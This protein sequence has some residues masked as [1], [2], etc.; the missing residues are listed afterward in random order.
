MRC[1]LDLVGTLV[2]VLACASTVA[3]DVCVP[4]S[5]SVHGL[6]GRV[7]FELNGKREPLPDVQV[8]VTPYGYKKPPVATSVTNEVG[9]F[10]LRQVRPGRYYLTVRHAVVIGLSVEV[11]V[12]KAKR[13]EEDSTLIE[14]VLRNDPTKYC[15]GATV[16]ARKEISRPSTARSKIME[17][18]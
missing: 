9:E 1:L 10:L 6:R 7:Y 13:A 17:D 18:R 16:I 14:I 11:R 15:A 12:K 4:E 5:L 8:E 2:V 3:Q